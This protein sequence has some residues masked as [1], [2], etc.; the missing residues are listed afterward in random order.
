[1]LF[2]PHYEQVGA[3]ITQCKLNWATCTAT[4]E[5]QGARVEKSGYRRESVPCVKAGGGGRRQDGLRTV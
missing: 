1:M 2:S 3:C 4:N 5:L